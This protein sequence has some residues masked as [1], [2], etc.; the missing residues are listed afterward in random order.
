MTLEIVECGW[1]RVEGRRI[2][3]LA[4][5][6]WGLGWGAK[7]QAANPAV[8]GQAS[9]LRQSFDATGQRNSK[10]QAATVVVPGPEAYGRINGYCQSFFGRF[11][12]S[13]QTIP[14]VFRNNSKRFKP[15]PM[16]SNQFQTLFKKIMKV[17]AYGHHVM[18][19]MWR[20][21]SEREREGRN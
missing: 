10:L 11:Q 1:L 4:S 3:G 20:V 21:T 6:V 13:F 12:R 7:L 18:C 17:L 15:I 14:K 9:R 8:A 19:D 5:G 2:L 16:I